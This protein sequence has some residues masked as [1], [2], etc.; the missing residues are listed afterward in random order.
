M[1]IKRILF[2]PILL[3]SLFIS[4]AAADTPG[5]VTISYRLNYIDRIAS[6]QVA[7]WVEDHRGKYINTLYVSGF[8]ASGGYRE[9][10]DALPEWVDTMKWAGFESEEIDA[11]S[12]PTRKA[13][14]YE[15][16]WDCTDYKGNPVP[17]GFY[18]IKIEG[19]IFW[20]N[21]VVWKCTFE[22]GPHRDRA[23]EE[24]FFIPAEA[25]SIERLVEDVSA[26][27]EPN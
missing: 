8:T 14:Q 18:V 6:N 24:V 25:A 12:A 20:E 2:I 4:A 21:R 15:L 17:R 13:G 1:D 16:Q 22:V 26:V 9:R 19:N 5:T 27:F 11:L 23:K 3:S 7:V 10:P